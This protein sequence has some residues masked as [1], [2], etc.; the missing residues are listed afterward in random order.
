MNYYEAEFYLDKGEISRKDL[1]RELRVTSNKGFRGS[2]LTVDCFREE[3][4]Y[5]VVP[6]PW[7]AL[8]GFTGVDKTPNIKRFWEPIE[9]EYWHNQEE[10]TDATFNKLKEVGCCRVIGETG[11]GKSFFAINMARLL[12]TNVLIVVPTNEILSQFR[13]TAEDIFKISPGTIKGKKEDVGE[14]VT[15]V[16]YQ[17]LTRRLKNNPSYTDKFGMLCVDEAHLAGCNS[18]QAVLS[19]INAKY[20]LCVSADFYRSD[21]LTKVYELCLGEVAAVGVK[22]EGEYLKK[23][24]Y[25]HDL[26]QYVDPDREIDR[27]GEFS[28]VRYLNSLA[29]S[30]QYN[31]AIAKLAKKVISKGDRRVLISVKRLVQ[32]EM[33]HN[34][35][36][37]KI[38]AIFSGKTKQKDLAEAAKAKVI[39]YSKS[40]LGFDPSKFLGK[41]VEE[42]LTPLNTVI[43]TYPNKNSKQIN[44]RG[45]RQNRGSTPLIILLRTADWY[46]RGAVKKDIKKNWSHI[47]QI[48][49]LSDIL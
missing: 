7:A 13:E 11:W 4:E 43:V 34:L 29:E 14:L 6:R 31:E 16:T 15:L 12:E 41:E 17:T 48:K 30:E 44:G 36:G 42:S 27:F 9:V 3:D 10:V 8:N 21:N 18:I 23:K 40:D 37:P 24:L 35:L 19:S 38:S 46:H 49:S 32:A 25:I 39:I 33:L 28:Y 22:S 5:W 1:R 26:P 45:G 47:E 20:R 2:T